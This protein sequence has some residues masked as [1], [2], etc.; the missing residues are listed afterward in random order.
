[1]VG[2]ILTLNAGSSSL[3]FALF[4]N[5]AA[6]TPT[7]RGEIKNLQS[8]PHLVA[9]DAKGTLL[10]PGIILYLGRQGKSFSAIED[11][12][13]RHSG[14]LGVPGISADMR[15]FLASDDAHAK[16]ALDL[17]TYRIA[18]EAGG[19]V[20]ALCTLDSLVFVTGIGEHAPA[21]RAR[22]AGRL[23]WLG[24]RLDDPANETGKGRISSA[25]SALEVFVIPTDEEAMIAHHTY[26]IT[27]AIG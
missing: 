12:L 24:L 14:L 4:D 25:D 20:G 16:E 7:A 13:Y 26:A 23:P 18:T 21:I 1:M 10:D 8:A 19:L 17:F 2:S 6:L 22:V 27:K 11:M 5:D 9:R 3:K 15:V